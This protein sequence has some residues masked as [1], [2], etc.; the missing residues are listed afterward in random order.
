MWQWHPLL[1]VVSWQDFVDSSSASA[2]ERVTANAGVHPPGTGASPPPSFFWQGTPSIRD[3]FP[4]GSG[5]C[6]E[7]NNPPPV[8][9]S[10]RGL[11]IFPSPP[12][13]HGGF[14]LK[15]GAHFRLLLHDAILRGRI[16][17]GASQILPAGFLPC[18]FLL[19]NR[20]R[21]PPGSLELLLIN[22]IHRGFA[23]LRVRVGWT[24]AFPHP[25]G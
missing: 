1:Y 19:P 15:F 7:K 23:T 5:F 4:E 6:K 22:R 8:R 25:L 3:S 10:S 24:T 18:G 17:A 20:G 13:P 2:P 11:P 21:I 14:S 12:P 9:C 16:R